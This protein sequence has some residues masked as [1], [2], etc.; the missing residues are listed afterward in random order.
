MSKT[1][2]KQGDTIANLSGLTYHPQKGFQ[3]AGTWHATEEV[4]SAES[5]AKLLC[6]PATLIQGDKEHPVNVNVLEFVEVPDEDDEPDEDTPA[7]SVEIDYADG[8][9]KLAYALGLL[10]GYS[11]KQLAGLGI[12]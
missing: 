6:G 10:E 12:V 1:T 5:D 9:P 8:L 3:E 11:K 2:L 4:I 7:C